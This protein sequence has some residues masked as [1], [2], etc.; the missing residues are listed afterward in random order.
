MARADQWARKA[1]SCQCG[2]LCASIFISYSCFAVT[3]SKFSHMRLPN[4]D[5]DHTAKAHPCWYQLTVTSCCSL[6]RH[7]T[8]RGAAS[9]KGKCENLAI[10]FDSYYS[11]WW[12]Q[13]AQERHEGPA[14]GR[15]I[16]LSGTTG[17]SCCLVAYV[18]QMLSCVLS[19]TA[20]AWPA[21]VHPCCIGQ[22]L[23]MLCS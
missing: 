9:V 2:N 4:T 8:S 18:A 15:H 6:S 16:L 10:Y 19:I 20:V 5:P 1:Q 14:A 23:P 17:S 3:L 12:S 7:S 11:R 22:Q 21:R 13:R